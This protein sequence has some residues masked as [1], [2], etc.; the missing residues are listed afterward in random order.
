MEEE[1]QSPVLDLLMNTMV[2]LATIERLDKLKD[3]W[4]D[5][6]DDAGEGIELGSE[7]MDMEIY[8]PEGLG[9]VIDYED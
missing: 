7:D 5:E 2:K 8:D 4:Y 6:E 9:D 3:G 1:T